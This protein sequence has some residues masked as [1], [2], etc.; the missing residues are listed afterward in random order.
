MTSKTQTESL[1]PSPD[2][3]RD[4]LDPALTSVEVMQRHTLDPQAFRAAVRSEAFR[5]AAEA[6]R[7]ADQERTELLTPL[8][9][10]RALHTL[11]RIANQPTTTPSQTE[12]ARRASTALLKVGRH[13]VP[14]P[15]P[16]GADFQSASRAQP[17]PLP[18]TP[19]PT[20]NPNPLAD[21]TGDPT[22][23]LEDSLRL[24]AEIE[25]LRR[26]EPLPQWPDVQS[27]SSPHPHPDPAS[28][29]AQLAARAGLAP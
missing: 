5:E 4:L 9:H 16:R 27:A 11:S 7:D 2:L 26:G 13:S 24:I 23:T 1:P 17:E 3:L 18:P 8:M 15:P 21:I 10:A 19:T 20:P 28:P 14:T 29:A 22:M 12:S 25:A 6:L